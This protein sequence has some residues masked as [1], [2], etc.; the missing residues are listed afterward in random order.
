MFCLENGFAFY[1]H[2]M[3]KFIYLKM[4]TESRLL[5]ILIVTLRFKEALM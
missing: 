2:G 4:K 1:V 3:S 5:Q